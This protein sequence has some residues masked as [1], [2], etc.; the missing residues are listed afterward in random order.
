M[1][2]RAFS[3]GSFLVALLLTVHPSHSSAQ[4]GRRY[5]ITPLLNDALPYGI[6]NA[7]QVAGTAP[8]G[9]FL[10]D[11]L[12]GKTTFPGPFPGGNGQT[13][14]TDINNK[15]QISGS[16]YRADKAPEAFLYD[17]GAITELGRFGFNGGTV[18]YRIND[19]GQIAAEGYQASGIYHA[20]LL[21]RG[22]FT[23]LGTLPGGRFSRAFGINGL[24]QVVGDSTLARGHHAFLYS[25]GK[26]TDIAPGGLDSEAVGIND[27]GAIIGT[28]DNDGSGAGRAFVSDGTSFSYLPAGF[29]PLSLNNAGE[30]A[31]A[32]GG[33][34][35]GVSL[36][37]ALFRSGKVVDLNAALVGGADWVLFRAWAINDAGQIAGDGMQA[38]VTRGFLLTPVADSVPPELRASAD[39]STLWPPNGRDV[40]VTVSGVV[41]DDGTSVD[42]ATLRY[43]V[44][45]PYHQV[46]PHGTFA[47]HDDG[48]FSFPVSL[49]ASRNGADSNGRTYE[50]V[51]EAADFA[52]N[53]ASR[54][55]QVAVPHDQR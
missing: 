15:G 8:Q 46:Q 27:H 13:A 38:G 47:A 41:T 35:T 55:V 33:S 23:D 24:G 43:S 1:N 21:E 25:G 16:F 54:A 2:L 26:M 31:G 28:V 29:S 7:G 36:H 19:A 51:I 48:S 50:I 42:P 32:L 39:R 20:L 14:A 22:T 6:N 4:V 49:T 44:R 17:H 9:A 52:G 11:P 40:V 3:T 5:T 34:F 30:I 10:Y 12:T 53:S 18:G 45:D 37:A